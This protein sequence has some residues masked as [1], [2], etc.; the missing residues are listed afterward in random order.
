MADPSLALT[1]QKMLFGLGD[2]K[3][4]LEAT[5]CIIEEY[6]R[7]QLDYIV[8]KAQACM[9]QDC[10]EITVKNILF[11]LKNNP[12]R[13]QRLYQYFDMKSKHQE[14]TGS[15]IGGTATSD[16]D[17]EA[18]LKSFFNGSKKTRNLTVKQ[19]ILE[20]IDE[21]KIKIDNEFFDEAKHERLVRQNE[22]SIEQTKEDYLAFEQSRTVSFDVSY[23]QKTNKNKREFNDWLQ[24]KLRNNPGVSLLT[25]TAY[26]VLQYLSKEIVAQIVDCVL[27]LRADAKVQIISSS[28]FT[29]TNSNLGPRPEVFPIMPDEVNEVMRRCQYLHNKQFHN[30]SY[31]IL[32]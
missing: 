4:P 2:C 32:F 12:V 24:I 5:S 29:S 9:G 7:Q 27:Q 19:Q 10:E 6:L 25:A 3:K 15:I 31:C 23:R 22:L 21:F 16:K 13:L 30:V 1:I 28:D 11:L 8:F 17:I 18:D 26:E 20:F 14:I